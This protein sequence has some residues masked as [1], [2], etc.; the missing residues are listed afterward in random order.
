MTVSTTIAS[1]TFP[2]NGVAQS[3]PCDFRIFDD[4]N[5]EVNLVK[6]ADGT[7]TTLVLNTDY[8][9]S[10]AGDAAGFTLATTNPVAIGYTLTVERVMP[11][12]QPTDF[13]NQGSFFPSMH[14]DMADRLEMQIQQLAGKAS[15]SLVANLATGN[16]DLGANRITGSAEAVDP[17]DLVTLQQVQGLIVDGAAPALAGESGASFVGFKQDGSGAVLRTVLEKARESLSIKDFGAVCDG[18]T[19]DTIAVQA[20]FNA[21]GLLGIRRCYVPSGVARCTAKLSVPNGGIDIIGDGHGAVLGSTGNGVNMRG[22]G[23]WILFDHTDA[24][25]EHALSAQGTLRLEKVGIVRT[26]ATPIDVTFA[27]IETG[28]DIDFSGND[29]FIDD[30]CILNPTYGIYNRAGGRVWI[31]T[32]LGQ[33]LKVG[34]RVDANTDASRIR[35]VHFWPFWSNQNGVR[36]YQKLNANAFL[37][38]RMDNPMFDC[39]FC[40]GYA[41]M[42][43]FYANANGQFNKVRISNCDSDLGSAFI[44]VDSSCASGSMYIV[45]C[46]TQGTTSDYIAN[47][48]NISIGG[49]NATV[50]ISNTTLNIAQG[51]CLRVNGTGN[52]VFLTNVAINNWNQS[53]AG[54][55]GVSV[56]TSGNKVFSQNAP[57]SLWSSATSGM[58]GA[59]T[60]STLSYEKFAGYF[61]SDGGSTSK[62]IPDGWT[63]SKVGTGNYSITHNLGLSALD[64]IAFSFTCDN[65]TSGAIAQIDRANSGLNNVRIRTYVG[66]TATDCGVFFTARPVRT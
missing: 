6:D 1:Q 60:G 23:S 50:Y 66:T 57:I 32:L 19:D 51:A 61:S 21:C 59:T 40:I 63:V 42:F 43:S 14:E 41:R 24:G 10:G 47:F 55:T 65:T 46:V 27:P 12:E 44:T 5:V 53:G 25:I 52:K 15:R 54:Y 48:H 34:L 11:Y 30:V 22:A 31:D 64:D 13:T 8:T 36:V 38:Y 28:Y 4:T 62:R 56:A 16:Y 3:F 39:C 45:N 29:L 33:P 26:Q 20:A 49:S 7:A 2:G 18:T 9:I 35:N 58:I 17:L 37:I